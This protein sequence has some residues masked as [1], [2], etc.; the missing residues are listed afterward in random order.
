VRFHKSAV[1]VLAGLAAMTQVLAAPDCSIKS[2][3]QPLPIRPTALP[4]LTVELPSGS[5]QLGAPDGAFA[6]Q[7]DES[8]AVDRVELR[9]RQ[10]SC[11]PAAPS[12]A[13]YVPRT[14]WDNTPYRFSAGGDGK[15][16]NAADF[17][18]WMKAKGIH[19]SQGGATVV[20]PQPASAP[21]ASSST[22]S[23]PPPPQN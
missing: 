23:S 12:A 3:P 18:A 11:Q 19:V 8:E 20:A 2:V 4:P 13:A 10:E 9:Q 17:D 5:H 16:F 22:D 1:V 7:S 15:K 14:K 6:Y 21:A